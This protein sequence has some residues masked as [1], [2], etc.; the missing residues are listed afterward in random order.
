M[1]V[2]QI[3]PRTE[4]P[5]AQA[6]PVNPV[7]GSRESRPM[8]P[9]AAG[10]DAGSP[11]ILCQSSEPYPFRSRVSCDA[12]AVHGRDFAAG[13]VARLA[14]L[15]L[16]SRCGAAASDGNVAQRPAR[17]RPADGSRCARDVTGPKAVVRDSAAGAGSPFQR[18]TVGEPRRSICWRRHFC[19]QRAGGT[20]PR[21]ACAACRTQTKP[22]SSS[23]CG[24][25]ST[26]WRRRISRRPIRRC[27]RRH[28]RVA[29]RILSSAGRT[30]A[31]T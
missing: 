18:T 28:S 22:S 20:M 29:A 13:L 30:G 7:G 19:S 31:A 6:L 5:A 15:E 26:C 21:P 4:E 24:R 10:W 16:A 11:P 14:R 17:H 1:S 3:I 23:R 12:G 27:W 9:E 8:S 25:C 2:V